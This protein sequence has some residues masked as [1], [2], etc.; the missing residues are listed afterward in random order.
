MV[1]VSVAFDPN[2]PADIAR[3]RAEFDRYAPHQPGPA[4]LQSLCEQMLDPRRYGPTRRGLVRA[5]AEASPAEA[6]RQAIYDVAATIDETKNPGQMVGGLH[7][8]LEASWRTL[9]GDGEFVETSPSGFRMRPELASIVLHVLDNT[10]DHAGS[11][12]G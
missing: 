9:G 11:G 3:A 12:H 7:A 1:L 10:D 8:N 2:D 6:P 4:E 5:I